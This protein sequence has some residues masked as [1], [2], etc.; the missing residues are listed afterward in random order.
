MTVGGGADWRAAPR[1][2]PANNASVAANARANGSRRKN[3][4]FD[5]SFE[6]CGLAGFGLVAQ[7]AA[8]DSIG[9]VRRMNRCRR[10]QAATALAFSIASKGK[11][12]QGNPVCHARAAASL[13]ASSSTCGCKLRSD[14]NSSSIRVRT[15]ATPSRGSQFGLRLV[16]F[17]S[18][19]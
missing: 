13:S 19:W 3:V 1:L 12:K 11:N 4:V 17:M 15:A 5:I 6:V 18:V 16:V 8:S 14:G 9:S 2:Q 7:A 10:C